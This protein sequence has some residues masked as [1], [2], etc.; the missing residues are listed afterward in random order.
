MRKFIEDLVAVALVV[1]AEAWFLKGYFADKPEFEPALAFLGA[2]GVLLAKEP[3]RAR[4]TSA[5]E[6]AAAHDKELFQEFLD[7]LPPNQTTAF[8]KEHDFG[9]SFRRSAVQPLFAFAGIWR[10]V[11]K[12]FLDRDLEEKRRSLH[13]FASELVDEIAA[14]TVPL[15]NSDLASVF[16]DQQRMTGE[17]RPP[18]VIEDAKVLNEKSSLFVPMY[19]DFV[20]TCR[21]KLAK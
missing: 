19:E 13:K 20:R 10:S 18:S 1:G 15:R 16:S 9:G 2:L 8:Y 7:L 3:V 11:D 17:P 14:R 5:H 12:E 6:S 4:F 21:A